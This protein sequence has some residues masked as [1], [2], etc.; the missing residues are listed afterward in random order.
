[1]KTVG[2]C[3]YVNRKYGIHIGRS[4]DCGTSHGIKNRLHPCGPSWDLSAALAYTS[5]RRGVSRCVRRAR[6]IH[7][8][9]W[10]C[11]LRIA[12]VTPIWVR[13]RFRP[14]AHDIGRVRIIMRRRR[15]GNR[16]RYCLTVPIL[17]GRRRRLS[18]RYTFLIRYSCAPG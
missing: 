11:V 9:T 6:K 7:V 12:A 5:V 15:R 1:M 4:H 17:N 10:V 14:R 16:S 13:Y 18:Q 2:R 3:E 8:G